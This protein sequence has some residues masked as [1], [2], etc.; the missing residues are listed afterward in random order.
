MGIN[1]SDAFP[2]EYFFSISPSECPS[3]RASCAASR[4]QAE[5]INMRHGNQC[6]QNAIIQQR[7]SLFRTKFVNYWPRHFV[8]AMRIGGMFNRRSLGRR[9]SLIQKS[10]QQ[11]HARQQQPPAPYQQKHSSDVR[12]VNR[13]FR[14]ICIH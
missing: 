4:E 9:S 5:D 11:F 6:V 1:A 12:N 2:S 10:R 3:S 7:G 8:S 13:S 14:P